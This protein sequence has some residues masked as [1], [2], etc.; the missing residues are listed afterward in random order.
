MWV[1]MADLR[2]GLPFFKYESRFIERVENGSFRMRE[3][4]SREYRKVMEVFGVPAGRTYLAGLRNY[5]LASTVFLL[6]EGPI[7]FLEV[8]YRLTGGGHHGWMESFNHWSSWLFLV[9]VLPFL[10]FF[11]VLLIRLKNLRRA[12]YR[13]R[14]K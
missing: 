5:A 3:V 2:F 9:A 7:V 11:T 4:R 13:Y 10:G 14:S 12:G 1:I 8:A 6:F